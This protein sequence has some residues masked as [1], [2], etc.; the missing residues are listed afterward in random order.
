MQIDLTRCYRGLPEGASILRDVKVFGEMPAVIVRDTFTSLT[1]DV[2]ARTSWQGG[3]HPAWAFGDGWARLSDGDRAL[4]MVTS[5]GKLEAAQL[6]RHPG[7]RG[8]LT[9]SHMRR[10]RDGNGEQGWL[11]AFDR[12]CTFDPPRAEYDVIGIANKLS[13]S[14]TP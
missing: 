9:L 8:P 13:S 5:P 3:S 11:F 10:L 2:E 6:L 4:W 1:R 14:K 7:S 12:T